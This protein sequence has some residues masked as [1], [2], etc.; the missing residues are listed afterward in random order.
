[1]VINR[2]VTGK[3][4]PL[5]AGLGLGLGISMVI[6]LAAVG[7]LAGMVLKGTVGENAIGYGAMLIVPLSAALGALAAA[8]AVKH[9]WLIVCAG[10]GGLYFVTLLSI[11]AL[12]FGGQ[13]S[14]IGTIALLILLGV[15]VA[16]LVGLRGEKKQFKP[17]KKYR[18][19]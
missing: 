6:T 14:G 3:A 12:F 13:Y 17:K 4:M 19:R 10:V 7:I 9:R 11:T 2:K 16:G 5:P 1:M 15:G 18:T 8:L